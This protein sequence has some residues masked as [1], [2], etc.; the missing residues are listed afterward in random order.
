M[1]MVGLVALFGVGS[2]A[3]YTLTASQIQ[4]LY[5][6]YENPGTPGAG[7][8]DG[9]WLSPVQSFP[10]G[11]K[12]TGNVR[13][14]QTGWGQIQIGAEFWGY[15]F[16]DAP[17][18]PTHTPLT[19]LGIDLTGQTSYGIK[20]LNKN[21][22]TWMFNV[23]VNLGYTDWGETNYYAQNTWTAVAAGS[24]AGIIMDLTAAEVWGGGYTGETV[25]L[26]SLGIDFSHV[27]NI[28]FNIGGDMPVDGDHDYT[29]E[30]EVSPVPEPGTLLLL[31]S[32]LISLAGYG[33]LRLGRKKK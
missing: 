12:F 28:G 33:K 1:A 24:T 6:V 9:T 10:D 29:Y 13:T 15:G 2:A 30:V 32:G 23:Y 11:A 14:N 3:A 20:L 4:S 22:S 7:V 16:D 19:S 27:T 5:D 17:G 18:S 21:E 31:G 26:T 8:G 25:D